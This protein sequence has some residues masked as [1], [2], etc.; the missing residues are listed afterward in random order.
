MP[1]HFVDDEAQELLREIGIQLR[2]FGESSQPL[3]L[4]GLA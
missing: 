4:L 2:R 1:D 3:D